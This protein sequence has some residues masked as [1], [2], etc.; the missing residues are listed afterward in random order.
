MFRNIRWSSVLCGFLAGI[1]GTRII[2]TEKA[3]KIAEDLA[4]GGYIARDYI[5]EESE[6]AQTWMADV[7]AGGKE[8]AEQYIGKTIGSEEEA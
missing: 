7:L 3:K 5:L 1:V 4:T 6:Q 2:H 8:R